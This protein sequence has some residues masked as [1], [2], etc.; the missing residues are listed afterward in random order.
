MNCDRNETGV[1]HVVQLRHRCRGKMKKE[2][3]SGKSR[4]NRRTTVPYARRQGHE[5]CETPPPLAL[6]LSAR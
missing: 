6:E 4:S 1:D 5:S 3:N 2:S